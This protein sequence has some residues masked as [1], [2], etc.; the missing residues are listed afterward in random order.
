[1]EERPPRHKSDME[2]TTAYRF[3]S[4]HGF[5]KINYSAIVNSYSGDKVIASC[6]LISILRSWAETNIPYGSW[7]Q[8]SV[9]CVHPW[10]SSPNFHQDPWST[11][12]SSIEQKIKRLTHWALR[13]YY[14][15]GKWPVD[16][17]CSLQVNIIQIAILE[18]AGTSGDYFLSFFPIVIPS[19]IAEITKPIINITKLKVS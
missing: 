1:M 14:W 9:L 2:W 3:E 4:G 12:Q 15:N 13:G 18:L 16:R 5:S 17:R 6:V 19:V 7:C 11:S 8:L 10:I